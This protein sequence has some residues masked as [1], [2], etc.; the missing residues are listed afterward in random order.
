MNFIPISVKLHTYQVMPS[1]MHGTRTKGRAGLNHKTGC[2]VSTF[3]RSRRTSPPEEFPVAL[4]V[5]VTVTLSPTT[6][7]TVFGYVGSP[8]PACVGTA[9]PGWKVPY[10]SRST[11]MLRVLKKR[12]ASDSSAPRGPTVMVRG[13]NVR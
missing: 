11:A 4:M 1:S 12:A 10:T 8:L 3:D 5:Y 2:A 7:N 9:P 6:K 13:M